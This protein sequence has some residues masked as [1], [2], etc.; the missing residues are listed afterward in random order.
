MS[1]LRAVILLVCFLVIT[2]AAMPV[3]V[4]LLR[5]SRRHSRTF[6]VWYH[7]TVCRL[8]GIRIR[9]SGQP[10]RNQAVLIAA[11]HTS[12]FDILIIASVMPLS[13]VAKKEVASWPLFG[14]LAKLQRTVFVDRERRTN[15]HNDRN[16]IQQRL[17]EGDALVLFP[18]GTTGDGNG[19]MPFK[20]ALMGAA[21]LSR[22][23]REKG[24]PPT[25]VQPLSVAYTR[26]HGLP[27]GRQFRPY[28]AW[29]GDTELAPH[30]WE[31]L[32]QGPFDVELHFHRPV[33]IED[34]GSRKA[35]AAYCHAEVCCGVGAALAGR[36]P[37]SAGQQ[38]AAG[39][40]VPDLA[41]ARI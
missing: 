2:F 11:N 17:S 10:V 5:F 32:K 41:A 18:E 3:Q 15:A 1:N 25:L 6:P 12:Y 36:L 26:L 24:L 30:I 9:V 40:P 33:T 21:E 37:G 28:Y 35:L 19:V 38:T 16:A 31:A 14:S 22:G 23:D 13:F 29:Y 20:T 4:A 39:T 34:F 8:F 7:S 27:M